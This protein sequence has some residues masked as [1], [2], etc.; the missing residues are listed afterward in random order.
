MNELRIQLEYLKQTWRPELDRT[1]IMECNIS[2]HKC[3]INSYIQMKSILF[4]IFLC[5]HCEKQ[6]AAVLID[7]YE[8]LKEIKGVYFQWS[9][10]ILNFKIQV[11]LQTRNS[12][13]D[14]IV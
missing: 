13:D 7:I 11:H 12:Y 3:V 1:K 2:T 5:F 4:G 14:I 8:H 6:E 10:N 9:M